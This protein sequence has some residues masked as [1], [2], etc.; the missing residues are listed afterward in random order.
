MP[1]FLIAKKREL[2]SDSSVNEAAAKKQDWESLKV[3]MELDKHCLHK[4]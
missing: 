3:S 4:D 1:N 2:S